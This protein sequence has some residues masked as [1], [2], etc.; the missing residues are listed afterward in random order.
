MSDQKKNFTVICAFCD[1]PFIVRYA[2]T[3]PDAKGEGEV[4]AVCQFCDEKI[5]FTIPKKYI[6]EDL[7]IQ[8]I[9]S[10]PAGS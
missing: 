8:H 9:K 2:L 10:V 4:V 1:K 6:G 5:K 3:R 7:L